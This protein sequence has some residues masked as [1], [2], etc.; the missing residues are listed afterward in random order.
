MR[1]IFANYKKEFLKKWGRPHHIS[2]WF[3]E[4]LTDNLDVN[5]LIVSPPPRHNIT[6]VAIKKNIL[7]L[8]SQ[9]DIYQKKK[10]QQIK[11]IDQ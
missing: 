9:P 5:F 7:I 8:F 6:V 11:N 2:A 3:N 4:I 10:Y 1:F